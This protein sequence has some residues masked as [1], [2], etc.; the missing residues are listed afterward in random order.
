MTWL[1]P[2]CLPV[3]RPQAPTHAQPDRDE[4]GKD[5]EVGAGD[6]DRGSDRWQRHHLVGQDCHAQQERPGGHPD[7]DGATFARWQLLPQKQDRDSHQ[8]RRH[9]KQQCRLM[10]SGKN[11]DG[12]DCPTQTRRYRSDPSGEAGEC[13]K[14]IAR[15][16]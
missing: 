13:P 4:A 2:P 1:T 16:R 11:G 5:Q 6:G 3:T 9:L 8:Q 14:E 15:H 12:L 10:A 7:A